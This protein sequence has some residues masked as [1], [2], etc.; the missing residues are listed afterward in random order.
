MLVYFLYPLVRLPDTDL[1]MA[2]ESGTAQAAL[3][4]LLIATAS[5]LNDRG[6]MPAGHTVFIREETVVD[7]TLHALV[8]L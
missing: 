7:G 1:L 6:N 8:G 2:L 5:E 4:R 3:T